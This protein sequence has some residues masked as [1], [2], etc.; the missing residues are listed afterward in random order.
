MPIVSLFTLE[1]K[2]AN[3]SV[4]TMPPSHPTAQGPRVSLRDIAREVGVSHV[5]VSLALRGATR[6]SQ[7]TR[8]A[9]LSA[10]ARLGYQPDPMLSA[11]S[12]YRQ[13]KQP[14]GIRSTVAW[15]NQWT[16][17]R[18]LRAFQEFDA[19]WQGAH[20]YAAKLGYRLEEFVVK[21]E[22]SPARLQQI[23]LARNVRGILIP[24]HV[25]DL[26]LPG[27]DWDLFALVRLGTSVK[28]P[29]ADIVTSDQLACAAIAFHRMWEK[30][31]R[32]IGYI[33]SHR[34]DRNTGGH[35]RAGYLS[36][37]DVHVPLRRH[38]APCALEDEASAANVRALGRWLRKVKPD[39]ILSALS[40][41]PEMLT[42]AGYRVPD[43][44]S[45]AALSVLD[46]HYD[47]GVD[48]NS[49]EIGRVAMATLA[50][51]IH[52]N[53]RGI[54][55]YCRRILVEGRWIDGASL[56]PRSQAAP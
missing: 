25:N 45:V 50:S 34:F 30:G 47:A 51:L 10:A 39:A 18:H 20:A 43:D 5:T 53:E 9:I 27:F 38:I 26:V 4:S 37:Q 35:F 29:R 13:A 7:Q 42:H 19:Y 21:K 3:G 6:I 32:R 1:I 8:E 41:L 55:Q 22:M 15:L 36:A 33:S 49:L 28:Q 23:L 54:P 14:T 40:H 31:Y 52:Q 46:G 16:N 24:P 56:P 12:A 44:L 11:L 17:P 48:Q 2:T